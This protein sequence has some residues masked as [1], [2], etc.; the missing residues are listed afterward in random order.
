MDTKNSKKS[1]VAGNLQALLAGGKAAEQNVSIG[2]TPDIFEA[3]KNIEKKQEEVSNIIKKQSLENEDRGEGDS[4]NLEVYKNIF[5]QNPKF[6]DD[7]FSTAQL[8]DKNKSRIKK[9]AIAEKGEM[10][11]I[12]NNIVD[13]WFEFNKKDY[14][15]SIKKLGN[16]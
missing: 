4:T 6:K 8:F 15:K 13:F 12:L 7:K 2:K 1:A 14:Q 16:D 9:L 11:T 10:V 5:V 3:A